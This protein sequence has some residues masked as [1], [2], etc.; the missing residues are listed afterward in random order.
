M[1]RGQT[2]LEYLLV[3]MLLMS[4]AFLAGWL[5]RAVN[6]QHVRTQMLLGSDYP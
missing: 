6:T 4:A 3:M 2:T 1:K 5:V